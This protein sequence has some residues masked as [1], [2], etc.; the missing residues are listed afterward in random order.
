MLILTQVNTMNEKHGDGFARHTLTK[1]NAVIVDE[2]TGVEESI[3]EAEDI[4]FV[5]ERASFQQ[6]SLESDMLDVD[7]C[8]AMVYKTPESL[9]PDET[10]TE[11]HC[12]A[13]ARFMAVL[14]K[15]AGQDRLER[16][17]VDE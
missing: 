12:Q 15:L 7:K 6:G 17:V 1:K 14:V 3:A 16:I 4:F 13:A 2:E 8:P 10:S 9:C 5:I 11:E